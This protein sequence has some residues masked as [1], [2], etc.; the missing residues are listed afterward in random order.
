MR[1]RSQSNH[2]EINRPL[3]TRQ[4]DD[5]SPARLSSTCPCVADPQ[6]LPRPCLSS[7]DTR[8][9][10]RDLQGERPFR[11]GAEIALLLPSEI[12]FWY[13]AYATEPARAAPSVGSRGCP[14]SLRCA[15]IAQDGRAGPRLWTHQWPLQGRHGCR[16]GVG[17][18]RGCACSQALTPTAVSTS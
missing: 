10:A 14:L 8:C 6:C 13:G 18:Q 5:I 17:P 1:H 7:A 12:A 9:L 15:Q 3:G 16:R 4:V 2:P 11:T